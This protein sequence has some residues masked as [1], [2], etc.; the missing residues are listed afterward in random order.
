MYKYKSSVT[1]RKQKRDQKIR[2]SHIVAI[3]V[4]IIS[5]LS[6]LKVNLEVKDQ[7]FFSEFFT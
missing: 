4:P 6:E 5:Q 2:S 1:C 7:T 3:V